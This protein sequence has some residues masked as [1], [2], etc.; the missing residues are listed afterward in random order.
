MI[1]VSDT[2]PIGSLFLIDRLSLLPAIYGEVYIPEKVFEELL[3]LA[4]LRFEANFRIAE[5]LYQ[6]ILRQMGE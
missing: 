1:V 5:P 2:S 6:M 4:K 3:I